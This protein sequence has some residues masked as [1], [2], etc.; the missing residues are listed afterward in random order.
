M[1]EI[2]KK[3]SEIGIVPT[4][5]AN[6]AKDAV[7][8]A[9]ALQNGGLPIVEVTFRT[10][11]AEEALRRITA[12]LPEILVGAGT[13][14]T[15]A[16]AEKAIAAGAKFIV[17]P[18]VNRDVIKYCVDREVLMMPGC[19]NPTDLETALGFGLKAVKFFPAEAFG[20]L[21]TL[22]AIAPVYGDLRFIPMG[23]INPEN[24]N[25]Y[26]AFE[27][28]IACGGSWLDK[29]ALIK[30]GNF[31]AITKL[32]QEAIN[33]VLGFELA[34]L[35]I[36]AP[37][38]AS[39]LQIATQ[40]ANIFNFELKPGNSSNFTGSGIEVNKSMGLGQHGHLAIKTNNIT[41]AVAYLERIGVP[42]ALNTAKTGPD[43]K[44]LAVYLR[45]E[46]GGFAVH[47]LQKK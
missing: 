2:L 13:I 7:P 41:R 24:L 47:L 22:K 23:G 40:F 29:G 39:S 14:L 46:I 25:E 33:T 30:E 17:S 44:L 36:N 21:K 12:E 18:G 20:G 38:E 19:S 3:I 27:K 5:K 4:F 16:Q 11:A 43:G 35:G 6:D 10:A 26:L 15:V 8:F 37:D 34:H 42:V 32:A 28:V 1:N 9:K 31:A 45:N